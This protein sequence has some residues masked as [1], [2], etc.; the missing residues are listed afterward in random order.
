MAVLLGRFA[1]ILEKGTGFVFFHR[2]GPT[3]ALDESL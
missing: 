2:L 3:A 1:G